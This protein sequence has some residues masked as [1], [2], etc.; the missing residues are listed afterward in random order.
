MI[1]SLGK[2][3]VAKVKEEEQQ[4]KWSIVL[5]WLRTFFV[6]ADDPKNRFLEIYIG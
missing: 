5:S 4:Q 3:K 1:L 2:I 6:Q